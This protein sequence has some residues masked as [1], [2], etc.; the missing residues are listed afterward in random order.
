MEEHTHQ[1]MDQAIFNQGLSIEATSLYIVITT[2]V[3][4]HQPSTLEN[5]EARWTARHQD[6]QAALDELKSRSI[7]RRELAPDG[8][9]VHLPNP[10]TLWR[11]PS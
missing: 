4:E 8:Q 1:V 5:I 7:V 6:L 2:L 11:R 10:S 3:S 9:M